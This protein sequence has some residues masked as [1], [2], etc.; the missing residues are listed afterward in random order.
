VYI[1]KNYRHTCAF[2]LSKIRQTK[3]VASFAI[4]F[5]TLVE[6]LDYGNNAK[7]DRFYERLN[8]N[9][10]E[11]LLIQGMA[12]TFDELVE[13]AIRVDDAQYRAKLAQSRS[14]SPE[15][16]ASRKPR[17]LKSYDESKS[18]KESHTNGLRQ[19]KYNPGL[20]SRHSRSYSHSRPNSRSSSPTRKSQNHGPHP[21]ISDK[22]RNYCRE[23]DLCIRCERKGHWKWDCPLKKTAERYSEQPVDKSFENPIV[24]AIISSPNQVKD[25]PQVSARSEA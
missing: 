11:A 14:K 15:P 7:C 8:P 4:E 9:V 6:P 20:R 19:T 17:R 12:T 10:Q 16:S 25:S 2:K 1:D 5:K 21:P 13:Q 24:H 18:S 22:E 23:K 3:S